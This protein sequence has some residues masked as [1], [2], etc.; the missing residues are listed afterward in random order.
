MTERVRVYLVRHGEAERD[1]GGGDGARRLTPE[2]R[3]QFFAFAGS[4]AERVEISRVMTSPLARA[5]QTAEILAA[6]T[7]APIA[8]S[9]QL[10]PGCSSAR[11]L[12]ELAHSQGTGVAL[13]GHNPEMADAVALAAGRGQKLRPGAVAAVDLTDIGSELA[14]IEAPEEG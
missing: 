11:G 9:P 14:W 2:G 6:A 8:E 7:G 3:A 5:R 12:L 10:A 1:V 4:L 13:V